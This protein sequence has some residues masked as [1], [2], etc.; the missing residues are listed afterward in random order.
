LPAVPAFSTT[1]SASFS[2]GGVLNFPSSNG[3]TGSLTLAGGSSAAIPGGT[4]VNVGISNANASN[5]LAVTHGANAATPAALRGS[6]SGGNAPIFYITM[7]AT[8]SFVIP[9]KSTFTIQMP[10]KYDLSNTNYW[11]ASLSPGGDWNLGY[12]GPVTN[13]KSPLNF[14]TNGLLPIAG[15]TTEDFAVYA[16]S[17]F[18]AGPPPFPPSPTTYTIAG[19]ETQ[20]FTYNYNLP[21]DNPPPAT[22]TT[23]I[24]QTVQ[25]MPTTLPSAFGGGSGTVSTSSETDNIGTQTIALTGTTYLVMSKVK[26]ST[27]LVEPG[28]NQSIPGVSN[29]QSTT[30]DTTYA[31]QKLQ[32][33]T[34]P[35]RI[36]AQIPPVNGTKWDNTP[37]ST[38]D[39]TY[40]DGHFENRTIATNGTYI[41]NGTAPSGVGGT[42]AP[43]S[44]V[45]TASGAGVYSGPF[46]GY[47][48]S[49]V[50]TFPVATGNPPTI[51]STIE[52]EG[53]TQSFAAIPAW[54]PVKPVFYGEQDQIIG[55]ASIP[56]SCGVKGTAFHTS[57]GSARLDTIIGYVE[58]TQLD[59]YYNKGV[60]ICVVLSDGLENFYDWQRDTPYLFLF[61]GDA[62]PVSAVV[63]NETLVVKSYVA[64]SKSNVA[65][66]A[67]M[68]PFTGAAIVAAAEQHFA[69]KME[70]QRLERLQKMVKSMS[71]GK[72][73]KGGAR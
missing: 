16:R 63:T 61:S 1:A 20:D 64:G 27:F 11:I 66:T 42:P 57:H 43:I 68:D 37:A 55:N 46:L 54:Y 5:P 40:G 34:V 9:T 72:F 50:F 71:T 10:A 18:A 4:T 44:L 41:E 38:V 69:A 31:S 58:V 35:G 33:V 39:E 26:G 59:E 6:A 17:K 32:G 51:M 12:A 67:A 28:N 15:L 25:V 3:F 8:T 45:E 29:G 30:I 13:G 62:K 23:D 73:H 48:P 14:S 53:Q 52:I 7:Y 65:S 49:I 19:V 24:T 70:K 2:T 47:V 22:I 36:L 56:A 60:P 21:T